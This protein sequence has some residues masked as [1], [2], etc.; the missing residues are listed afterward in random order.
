MF[1]VN[2][3]NTRTRCEICSKLTV[4]TPE[5]RQQRRFSVFIVN[6]EHISHKLWAGKYQLANWVDWNPQIAKQATSEIWY[7]LNFTSRG[8]REVEN[9][10]TLYEKI[11]ILASE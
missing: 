7:Y 10:M 9:G 1:K 3:R 8:K 2:N 4:K 6:F 5:R 11:F